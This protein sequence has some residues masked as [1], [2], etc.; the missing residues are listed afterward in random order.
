MVVK[1]EFVYDE[2]DGFSYIEER[3]E[4]NLSIVK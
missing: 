1:W 4:Q 3:G 2:I